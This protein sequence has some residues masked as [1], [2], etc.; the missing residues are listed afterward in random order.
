MSSAAVYEIAMYHTGF[1]TC[2]KVD[3]IKYKACDNPIKTI[4]IMS[5]MIY[6]QTTNPQRLYYFWKEDK[7]SPMMNVYFTSESSYK[8]Y[9]KENKEQIKSKYGRLGY[10]FFVKGAEFNIRV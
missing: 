2:S 3:A 8:K 5:D 10:D 1:P 4:P 9:L 7:I 6:E